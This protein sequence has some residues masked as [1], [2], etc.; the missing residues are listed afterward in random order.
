[1]YVS[2]WGAKDFSTPFRLPYFL[3]LKIK[4][5]TIHVFQCDIDL[6][7]YGATPEKSGN[8]LPKEICKNWIYFEAVEVDED[9]PP[10]LLGDPKEMISQI[11]NTGYWIS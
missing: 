6:S 11:N 7:Q 10:F 4:I 8:S 3:T 2:Y 9:T 1:M 5:M